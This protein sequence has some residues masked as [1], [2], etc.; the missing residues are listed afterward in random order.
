MTLPAFLVGPLA[1]IL[2]FE[3]A[4]EGPACADDEVGNAVRA[5][6]AAGFDALPAA[7]LLAAAAAAA[8]RLTALAGGGGR[9]GG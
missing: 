2:L 1:S 3:A 9:G 4:A 7:S 5:I 6:G 8:W